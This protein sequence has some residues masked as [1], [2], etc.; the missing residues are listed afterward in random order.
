MS[1][2]KR[3]R[4]NTTHRGW[5]AP[6]R[7]KPLRHAILTVLL[8]Q[9]M[10][11]AGMTQE[12][13]VFSEPAS[14]MPARAVSL[15]YAGRFQK[16]L[17]SGSTEHR[18]Y[19]Y[20]QFGLSKKWMLRTGTTFSSMYSYPKTRWES[21]NLYAK[22]RFLSVD[23]V[24]RHF[25]MAAF[26]EA[27]YSRNNPMYDE[28]SMEGDQSGIQAGIVMTQLLHKLAISST[29]SVAEV[30]NARRWDAAHTG[31]HSYEAFNYSVSAGYLLFPRRYNSYE[32]TNINLYLELI[33]SR[34]LDKNKFY[35][36]LAPAIQLI[37][38]SN[39]K[40]NAGYRFQAGGNMFRMAEKSFLISLETTFLNKLKKRTS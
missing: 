38:N 20:A 8:L 10:L 15:K 16:G 5:Q 3:M 29:L 37:L 13:Y 34:N 28:I 9:A 26:A 12:L 33:G 24:H 25:R 21:V 31:M 36:D 35:V 6:H 32:Q 17:V 4:D 40:L 18:Q 22:Y 27:A 2:C 7:N 23:D 19:A 11:H 1:Q 30:L 14:N 39:T